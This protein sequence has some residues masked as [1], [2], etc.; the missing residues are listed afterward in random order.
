MISRDIMSAF[1][2]EMEKIALAPK[3]PLTAL[4]VGP[5]STNVGNPSSIKM[6]MPK[7]PA[8]PPPTG[9]VTTVGGSSIAA[10]TPGV[11]LRP[12]TIQSQKMPLQKQL[13]PPGVSPASPSYVSPQVNVQAAPTMQGRPQVT[14]AAPQATG[15]GAGSVAA[16]S[17]P[18]TN[19]SG[20]A[21]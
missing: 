19:M 18:S 4:K 15:G 14:Q 2:D 5:F 21:R 13:P 17:R 12:P 11:N 16:P 7:I 3:N 6:T 10:Q 8:A 20:G 1:V 9:R